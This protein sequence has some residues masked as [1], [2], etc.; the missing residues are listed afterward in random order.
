MKVKNSWVTYISRGKSH[1]MLMHKF[2]NHARLSYFLV[3]K[4]DLLWQISL[5]TLITCFLTN[6]FILSGKITYKLLPEI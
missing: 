2:M 6:V 5:S 4:D 1:L 3:N